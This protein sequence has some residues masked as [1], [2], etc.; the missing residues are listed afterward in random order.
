MYIQL[1]IALTFYKNIEISEHV[2]FH[3]ILGNVTIWKL[4]VPFDFKR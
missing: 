4:H 1:N 3:K 2:F